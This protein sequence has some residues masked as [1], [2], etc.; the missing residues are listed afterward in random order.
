MAMAKKMPKGMEKEPTTKKGMKADMKK[1]AS[2][3]KGM[4]KA[5]PS[6][7]PIMYD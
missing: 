3:M 1:D 5:G 7:K 2:M 4:G 6:K